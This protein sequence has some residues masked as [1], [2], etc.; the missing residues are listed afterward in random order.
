MNTV[1]RNPFARQRITVS[2]LC[3]V[4]ALFFM[5]AG[6]GRQESSPVVDVENPYYFY[7]HEGE[8]VFLSLNTKYAFLSVKEPQLPADIKQRGIKAEE[9][10]SDGSDKKGQYLGKTPVSRYCTE[11]SIEKYLTNEQYLELLADIKR[12]NKDVIIAPYFN[13]QFGNKIGLSNFFFVKL[14][15]EDNVVLLEQM[16]KETNCIILYQYEFSPVWFTLSVSEASEFHALECAKRFHESG[17]F[18]SAEPSLM[19]NVLHFNP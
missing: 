15:K 2:T 13:D 8:K 6:C 10:L 4:C 9:F 16:A 19:A 5:A 1:S 18:E 7:D 12:K 14:K 17:L 11:L 3:V